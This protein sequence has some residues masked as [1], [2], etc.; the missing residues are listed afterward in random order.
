M[1]EPEPRFDVPQTVLDALDDVDVELKD[2]NWHVGAELPDTLIAA[3]ARLDETMAEEAAS[4]GLDAADM[5]E[6]ME[7]LV[8]ELY[9]R[10]DQ[11]RYRAARISLEILE[12][13][14]AAVAKHSAPNN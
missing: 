12:A 4:Q 9:R 3:V 14:I 2:T 6:T 13:G 10:K 7:K 5:I 11:P 1:T 8:Y